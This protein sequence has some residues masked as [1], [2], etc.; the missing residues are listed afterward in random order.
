MSTNET[1]AFTVRMPAEQAE[2][3]EMI[4]QAEGISVAE[5]VRGALTDRINARK[6][7]AEFVA[8]VQT[9]MARNQRALERLAQRA[10]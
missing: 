5:E 4:A 10:K 1:R 6:A 9:Q 2:E 8:R 3:L 7:D